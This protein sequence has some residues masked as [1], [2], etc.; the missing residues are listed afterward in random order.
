MPGRHPYIACRRPREGLKAARSA[1]LQEDGDQGKEEQAVYL[2]D[3]CDDHDGSK[4]RHEH[5]YAEYDRDDVGQEPGDDAREDPHR[6]KGDPD[7]DQ[8]PRAPGSVRED[9]DI[10]LIPS[11]SLCCCPI[12]GIKEICQR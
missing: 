3:P 6:S 11:F 7:G 5:R 8:Q 2:D 9:R 1:R 12:C 10:L 4:T